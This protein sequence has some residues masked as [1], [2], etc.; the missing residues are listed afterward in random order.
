MPIFQLKHLARLLRPHA[1]DDRPER[2][3]KFA[4]MSFA[5]LKRLGPSTHIAHDGYNLA[6]GREL[7]QIWK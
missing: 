3:N 7:K 5:K 4:L 1:I 2:P 6:L